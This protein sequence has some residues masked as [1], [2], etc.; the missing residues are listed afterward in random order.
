MANENGL[1]DSVVKQEIDAASCWSSF[2]IAS[3]Q[4]GKKIDNAKSGLQPVDAEHN[5]P[6]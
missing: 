4:I 1:E 5:E 6:I 3:L 2:S